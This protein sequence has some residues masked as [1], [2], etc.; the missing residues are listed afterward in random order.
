MNEEAD[1]HIVHGR[2]VVPVREPPEEE[3]TALLR[4]HTDSAHGWTGGGFVAVLLFIWASLGRT[5]GRADRVV[6][7]GDQNGLGRG[8]PIQK[9]AYSH[10]AAAA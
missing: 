1:H 8:C 3:E 7:A 2:V 4:W 10:P 6:V 5:C 9:R